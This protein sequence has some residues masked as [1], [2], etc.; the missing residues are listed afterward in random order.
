[1]KTRI[2]IHLDWQ[3]KSPQKDKTVDILISLLSC[4]ID[5][6]WMKK[7]GKKT[8]LEKDGLLQGSQNV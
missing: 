4:A 2:V 8:D 3:I 6:A 7:S 1:M 5:R